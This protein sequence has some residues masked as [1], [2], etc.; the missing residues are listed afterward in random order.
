M[1]QI[2]NLITLCGR[3]DYQSF[4][5]AIVTKVEQHISSPFFPDLLKDIMNG[6][7]MGKV[8]NEKMYDRWLACER[9][10]GLFFVSKSC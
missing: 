5:K 9:K 10:A 3:E 8:V 4:A 1:V 2:R 7:K 6:L